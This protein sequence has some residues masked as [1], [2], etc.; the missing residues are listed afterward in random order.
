ML[1]KYEETLLEGWEDVHKRGQ[2]TLWILLALKD[3]PKHMQKIKRFISDITS[4]SISA[5]DKSMYRALR[6]F[7]D[8]EM[9]DFHLKPGKGGP[10][11]KVYRLTEIGKNVLDEF[12]KKNITSIL[13]NN[14]V[15]ELLK[16][17][18]IQSNLKKW[19]AGNAV[20]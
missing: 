17:T 18:K 16:W 1:S 10:E 9:V 15:K 2:L 11:L 20:G 6:R 8:A 7:A 19:A 12:V 5:D 13:F 14:Q 3:G 4:M